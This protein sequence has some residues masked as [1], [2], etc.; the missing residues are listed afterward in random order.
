MS[1]AL[2]SEM[3]EL[4][5]ATYGAHGG[6]IPLGD[7]SNQHLNQYTNKINYSTYV[8]GGKKY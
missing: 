1:G 2:V 3:I 5:A 4:L 8:S 7:L 6:I